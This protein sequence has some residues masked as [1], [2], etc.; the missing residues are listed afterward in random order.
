MFCVECTDNNQHTQA[1]SL[2]PDTKPPG[3]EYVSRRNYNA[4]QRRFLTW[5]FC[6]RDHFASVFV[7][8]V[9]YIVR[10]AIE[11][12]CSIFSCLFR[13]W[14]CWFYKD[15]R[16]FF[17]FNIFYE[18]YTFIAQFGGRHEDLFNPENSCRP[19]A[20][21]EGDMNFLGWTNLHVSRLTGQ[22]IV[23]YTKAEGELIIKE[24]CIES[25]FCILWLFILSEWDLARETCTMTS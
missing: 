7:L 20:K 18:Y 6:I 4:T 13:D 23:Y 15:H 24:T 9:A 16:S 25:K 8:S 1:H 2:I 5:S 11:S 22:L 10:F 17:N 19:R 14:D 21:P 12:F 3:A